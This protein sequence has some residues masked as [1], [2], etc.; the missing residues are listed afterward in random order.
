MRKIK[1]I[2]VRQRTQTHSQGITTEI[3][4][5]KKGRPEG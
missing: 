3:L 1:A 4:E 2:L 5:I